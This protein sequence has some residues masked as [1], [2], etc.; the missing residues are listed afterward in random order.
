MTDDAISP[1]EVTPAVEATKVD[2]TAEPAVSE[3]TK[4]I[5]IASMTR[6]ILDEIKHAPLDLESRRRVLDIHESSLM[7]LRSILSEDLQEEFEEIF[8]PFDSDEPPSETELRITHA[9][10]IGW[11]EG[12]FHGIQASVMT[13]Q[14]IAH[15]LTEMA[16]RPQ[17]E[18]GPPAAHLPE[19]EEYPGVYL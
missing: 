2:E 7:E 6:A 15:Q 16:S 18:P 17:L 3:P 10:L 11:L 13:Q 5:R 4:L 1:D 14:M 9:Q 12:L 19:G 8:K